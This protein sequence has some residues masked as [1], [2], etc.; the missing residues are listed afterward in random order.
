MNFRKEIERLISWYIPSIILSLVVGY[1]LSSYIK[2]T[3]DS[4]SVAVWS[5]IGS[6]ILINHLH[7]I[8]VAIWLYI[9]SKRLNQKYILWSLFGLVAHLF[10]V[11]IFLVLYF[12]ET[13]NRIENNE[14]KIV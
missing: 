11:V 14:I 5:Y 12:Y 1:I 9:I 7:N 10:A 13:N 4:S 3:N 8:V 2:Y 6:N